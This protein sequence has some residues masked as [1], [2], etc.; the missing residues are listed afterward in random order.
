MS[1]FVKKALV[2]FGGIAV[3]APLAC[4]PNDVV[5]ADIPSDD[6]GKPTQ[7]SPCVRDDDCDT[8]Q[9]CE[10]DTCD[11]QV[12]KCHYK[13]PFCDSSDGDP[14]CGCDGVN[15]WNDCLR[16]QQGVSKQN[17]STC[18]Y[19]ASCGN[20]KGECANTSAKCGRLVFEHDQCSN[21]PPG[22]CW[23]LPSSCSGFD[24]HWVTCEPG[25][26]C[27]SVCDAIASEKPYFKAPGSICP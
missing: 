11:A 13:P 1:L 20:G 7:Q 25:G 12:G 8:N 16:N 22:Q 17:D 26:D 23:V 24:P 15:Y 9:Y 6:G 21:D 18:E 14:K 4:A 2:T 10:R 5:I 19:G 3:L 27:T